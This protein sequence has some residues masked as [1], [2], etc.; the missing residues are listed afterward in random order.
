[1]GVRSFEY[2]ELQVV[3]QHQLLGVRMQVDLLVYRIG[4][5]VPIQVVLEQMQAYILAAA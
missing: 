3:A 4:N 2:L 5:W 1:M